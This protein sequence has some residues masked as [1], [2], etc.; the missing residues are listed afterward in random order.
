M[1]R[2]KGTEIVDNKDLV[3]KGSKA[4]DI[5]SPKPLTAAEI[6]AS[7]AREAWYGKRQSVVS[8][9][10]ATPETRESWLR[11]EAVLSTF[12]ANSV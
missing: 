4:A 12:A 3:A 5:Q 6:R 1:V 9:D 8:W 7:M 2:A 11:V 10:K